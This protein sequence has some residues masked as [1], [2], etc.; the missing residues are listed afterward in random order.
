[1]PRPLED[2]VEFSTIVMM[3]EIENLTVKNSSMVSMSADAT[4]PK[5]KPM[6]FLLTSI[7]ITMVLSTTTSSSLLSEDS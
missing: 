1:M 4:F 2:L 3:M 6:H 7:P 5:R